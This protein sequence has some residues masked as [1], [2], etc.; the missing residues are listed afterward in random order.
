MTE[1]TVTADRIK[2]VSDTD[3]KNHMR[4]DSFPIIDSLLLFAHHSVVN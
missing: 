1:S 2:A 3:K 4:D